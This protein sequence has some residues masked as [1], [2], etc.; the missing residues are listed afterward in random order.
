MCFLIYI[1]MYRIDGY[2]REKSRNVVTTKGRRWRRACRFVFFLFFSFSF[3]FFS[4]FGNVWCIYRPLYKL[5][6]P[7]SSHRSSVASILFFR[8]CVRVFA[9]FWNLS[10]YS[11]DKEIRQLIHTSTLMIPYRQGQLFIW[12][13]PKNKKNSDIRVSSGTLRASECYRAHPTESLFIFFLFVFFH[14]FLS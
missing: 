8:S 3:F 6:I 11:S 13:I 1:Y 4:S 5:Y 12:Y 7:Y 10:R 14:F 2:K 9:K